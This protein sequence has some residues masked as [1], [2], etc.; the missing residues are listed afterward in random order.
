MFKRG[1]TVAVTIVLIILVLVASLLLW[2]FVN[3]LLADS[4]TSPSEVSCQP[5]DLSLI[6][7][8]P[9][10]D[11]E[12]NEYNGVRV[13]VHR[14]A[15][16]TDLTHLRFVFSKE[17]EY[18]L[19][20]Q[21][22]QL[23]E[24]E[25][26]S[27][28]FSSGTVLFSPNTIDLAGILSDGTVCPLIG[29]IQCGNNVVLSGCTDGDL[30]EG[31]QCDDGNQINDDECTNACTFPSCGDDICSIGEDSNNCLDDCPLD[32]PC[33]LVGAHWERTSAIE[34]ETIYLV[35]ESEGLC[36]GQ[37]AT[38]TVNEIDPFF[39]DVAKIQ[40]QPVT[41]TSD[42]KIV[43]GSWVA[44]W[45]NE[46]DGPK[47]YFTVQLAN[48][49]E[50]KERSNNELTTSQ[51]P[52]CGNGVFD[53]GELCD[54][55]N[56]AN[57]DG[58]SSSCTVEG[59]WD[60]VGV[61]SQCTLLSCGDG[62]CT[63]PENGAT[64]PQDC[65]VCGDG[66]KFGT[67][68]CDG[69]TKACQVN[70]YNGHQTCNVGCTGYDSC[71]LTEW[72]GDNKINDG[73][74]CD[75]GNQNNGDGCSSICQKEQNDGGW[76][77]IKTDCDALYQKGNANRGDLQVTLLDG[78][79]SFEVTRK[80]ADGSTT[81][82]RNQVPGEKF[83]TKSVNNPLDVKYSIID[84]S[85][86]G[87]VDIEYTIANTQ[88]GGD[89]LWIP[90]YL[91]VQG[92]TQ[93]TD[94]NKDGW[95]VYPF[96]YGNM[97]KMKKNNDGSFKP[98][99]LGIGNGELDH[100]V[101]PK[102]YSPVIL[103][104][105]NN[106]AVGSSLMYP[107]LDYKHQAVMTLL[108][109]GETWTHKYS[110]FRLFDGSYSTLAPGNTRKY[111]ISLRFTRPD[112]DYSVFILKPYKDHF[113]NLYSAGRTAPEKDLRPVMKAVM[114]NEEWPYT[115]A[116]GNVVRRYHKSYV[117]PNKKYN[118]LKNGF[119]PLFDELV[120]K[121]TNSHFQRVMIWKVSGLYTGY[122]VGNFP[123]QFVDFIPGPLANPEPFKKFSNA[124]IDLLLW[125]GRST[126]IPYSG[127][128]GGG[129]ILTESEWEPSSYKLADYK[130]DTH[131]AFLE[132]QIKKAVCDRWAA[133]FGLDAFSNMA[134]YDRY[135]WVEDMKDYVDLHCDYVEQQ[136]GQ[137]T[138]FSGE[139]AQPDFIHS[140]ISNSYYP[141]KHV[142]TAGP[143]LL[144]YYINPGSEIHLDFA[145]NRDGGPIICDYE[146][147]YNA[148][149]F[150]EVEKH[151]QWGYTRYTGS[152]LDV[153]DLNTVKENECFDRKNNGDGDN[154][155]D[156]P[157]D[158]QCTSFTDNDE[159]K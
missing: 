3:P 74:T 53:N 143:D 126:E 110:E 124:G 8:A 20:D 71:I 153:K 129:H 90:I 4:E 94:A 24:S 125:W 141:C 5:L 108:R 145:Q 11:E 102:A 103:T 148:N 40:P 157:F 14:G 32:E 95:Y 138:S 39:D 17:A 30:D 116:E 128:N 78:G 99:Y 25:T 82:L 41:F 97:V 101:Y 159:S 33:T 21:E 52:L 139:G 146:N 156:F 89:N 73:E 60:C 75:D 36:N 16:S 2:V 85:S 56:Y 26:H 111:T 69:D 127:P 18:A 49:P 10:F 109:D 147:G 38:L 104:K 61:P 76:G 155:K 87:G 48:H 79:K 63:L 115:D 9:T 150:D 28:I 59:G 132:N 80:N 113:N 58:C 81:K 70:G 123:P 54:D 86:C 112:S 158:P 15:G 23:A 55:G 144:S 122:K 77:V 84:K 57:G 114:A 67:E 47:Y 34:G 152:T 98:G 29:P 88:Q 27:F 140:R 120:E 35:V 134:P 130:D 106:F 149:T 121:A 83:F 68:A 137:E 66:V 45:Q 22:A 93:T 46:I 43:T 136:H 37:S 6:S 117:D 62:I 50:E 91:Q 1:N 119:G 13:E 131:I 100:I 118:F 19:A 96:T 65:N 154:V 31:E 151:T 105:D 44:E 107:Y 142:F 92:I 42:S 133:G 51:A 12:T 72:C 135:E 7:C 64:C